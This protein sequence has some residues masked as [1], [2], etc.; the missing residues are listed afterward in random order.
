MNNTT[1]QKNRPTAITAFRFRVLNML[2][3]CGEQTEAYFESIAFDLGLTHDVFDSVI[4]TLIDEGRIMPTVCDG[5]ERFGIVPS[6]RWSTPEELATA[7]AKNA[8]FNSA[9]L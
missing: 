8:A 5:G 3:A 4:D 1:T 2:V 9:A 7:T 6:L